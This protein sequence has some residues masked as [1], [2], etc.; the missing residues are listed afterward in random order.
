LSETVAQQAGESVR[1]AA[2]ATTAETVVASSIANG[3]AQTA[4]T[5]ATG[6]S[7]GFVGTVGGAFGITVA[8]AASL[9]LSQVNFDIRLRRMRDMY[10]D[11]IGAQLGKN[12]SKVT[13]K[14]METVA[15]GDASKGISANKT[16]AEGISKLKTKRNISFGVTTLAILGT[17]AI[18]L[19]LTAASGGATL[20]TGGALAAV[21]NFA[22]KALA[23]YAI[24]SILEKPLHWTAKKV[25]G[26]DDTAS[27]LIA[28]MR[29]QHK[30]G[31]VIT[32][33]QVV[34]AF[35]SGNKELGNFVKAQFGKEYDDLNVQQKMALTNS[36]E[37]YLP[38]TAITEKINTGQMK[39]SELAF[40]VEGQTSGVP[41]QPL[42]PVQ[43]V[44]NTP[45]RK[46]VEYDNPTPARSFVSR[47]EE[48][49]AVATRGLPSQ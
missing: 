12:P 38:V 29:R 49:R 45:K 35:V 9:V 40:A 15:K 28:D 32:R 44:Q 39:V 25:F 4:A 23:G 34:G 26:M 1:T 18:M 8:A 13:I 30:D 21:G 2:A 3:A 6:A 14:D 46:V 20:F 19:G 7:A 31:K 10:K 42:K 24:H 16:I 22:V 47:L 48:Q 41:L 33:E 5:A 11:E 17:M 27:D 37:Q 43:T 36:F